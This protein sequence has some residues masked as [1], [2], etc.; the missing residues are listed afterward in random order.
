VKR[1]YFQLL[2]SSSRAKATDVLF[3]NPFRMQEVAT[4]FE[5]LKTSYFVACEQR[6]FHLCRALFA[7]HKESLLSPFCVEY[8]ATLWNQWPEDVAITIVLRN[9]IEVMLPQVCIIPGLYSD[10]VDV[11][12]SSVSSELRTLQHRVKVTTMMETCIWALSD[13]AEAMTTCSVESLFLLKSLHNA[14][15]SNFDVP[16]VISKALRIIIT[17]AWSIKN[18]D[19]NDMLQ[20]LLATL[21]DRDIPLEKFD[22]VYLSSRTKVSKSVI[23]QFVSGNIVQS[24]EC[25][26]SRRAVVMSHRPESGSQFTTLLHLLVKNADA[27]Y[28]FERRCSLRG[29]SLGAGNVHDMVRIVRQAR[30]WSILK[31]VKLLGVTKV[32]IERARSISLPTWKPSAKRTLRLESVIPKLA[33]D[34]NIDTWNGPMCSHCNNVLDV[35]DLICTLCGKAVYVTYQG[36][37]IQQLICLEKMFNSEIGERAVAGDICDA[38]LPTLER[39]MTAPP[40][41]GVQLLEMVQAHSVQL[42][43]GEDGF[44]CII[45][46]IGSKMMF[47]LTCEER[48][49]SHLRRDSLL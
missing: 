17:E 15:N 34:S 28:D 5:D 42:F 1:F 8:L 41:V 11:S 19:S 21:F 12:H 48:H 27:L 7:Y 38:L 40:F 24:F 32:R 37:R 18:T 25:L 44:R 16:S 31:R 29:V 23:Q 49:L 43:V 13:F 10:L 47:A 39:R 36:N 3:E 4:V 22:C 35:F 2:P 20:L 45:P 9:L 14:L 33:F 46:D 30:D 6:D 26:S